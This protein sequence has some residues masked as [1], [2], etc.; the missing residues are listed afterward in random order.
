MLTFKTNCSLWNMHIVQDGER[1]DI[2]RN[3]DEKVYPQ[4][5]IKETDNSCYILFVPKMS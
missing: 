1:C 5:I 4:L 2:L 3:H